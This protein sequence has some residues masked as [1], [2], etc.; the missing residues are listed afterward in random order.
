[1]PV[2]VVEVD[3]VDFL[4]RALVV[5][6]VVVVVVFKMVQVLLQVLREQ[7]ILAEV[8]EV[9]LLTKHKMVEELL[10]LVVPVSSLSA[11]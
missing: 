4:H 10:E 2:V 11:T 1:M 8:V 6:V 5:L 9:L 7:T 3:M